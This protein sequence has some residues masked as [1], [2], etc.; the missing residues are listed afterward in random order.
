MT[1]LPAETAACLP[2]ARGFPALGVLRRL[3]PTPSLRQTTH[4]S[5][6]APGRD[7]PWSSTRWFPR[8]LLTARGR[9]CPA[10]PLRHRPGYAVVLHQGL[11]A[12]RDNRPGSP[13]PG[14][15]RRVR[16][17]TQPIS[18]R[19][20]LVEALRG[21]TSL[22]PRV[23]LSRSLTGPAP[24]GSTGTSRRCRGCSRPHPRLR[25]QAASHFKR[26]AT[27]GRRRSPFTSARSNS[28]SWRTPHRFPSSV[29]GAPRGPDRLAIGLPAAS[30]DVG[31]SRDGLHRIGGTGAGGTGQQ[32]CAALILGRL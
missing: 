7:R 29:A 9:R 3:R 21:F 18:A 24:S 12:K 17:A 31:Y 15:A 32:C 8:S 19:F 10:M 11:P 27:T 23:H 25:G 20:E 14:A 1:F 5:P 28:A 2:H 13:P 6:A 30:S 22:V 26:P 4:L 16:T